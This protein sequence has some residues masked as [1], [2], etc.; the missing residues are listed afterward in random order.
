MK[1]PAL[2][3]G[4][5]LLAGC[6]ANS[7]LGIDLGR[8]LVPPIFGRFHA[9][10]PGRCNPYTVR[11]CGSQPRM[12]DS[13]SLGARAHALA[14]RSLVTAWLRANASM[15]ALLK[16]SRSSGLRL[17]IQLRSRTTGSSFT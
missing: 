9:A 11:Q 13:A 14:A 10:K 3:S 6:V 16:A 4:F 12:L 15:N 7:C 1:S 8:S 17:V 2:H 5:V